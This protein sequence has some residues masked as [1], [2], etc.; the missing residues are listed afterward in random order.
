MAGEVFRDVLSLAVRIVRRWPQDSRAVTP[1]ALVVPIEVLDADHDGIA[2]GVPILGAMASHRS[3]RERD[4]P[5]ADV[6]LR[7]MRSDLPPEGES[8]RLAEPDDRPLD[9]RIAQDRR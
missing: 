6:Q 2:R 7:P 1:R 9:V 5:V 3:H 4:G 8:K